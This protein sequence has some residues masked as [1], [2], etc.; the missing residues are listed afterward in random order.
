MLGLRIKGKR[1]FLRKSAL[2]GGSDTYI[3]IS[4]HCYIGARPTNELR[5]SISLRDAE[6][7]QEVL[8][9]E[10]CPKHNPNVF[11]NGPLFSGID[12]QLE[13]C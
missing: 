1:I 6:A 8:S 5:K 4:H 12:G 11:A 10:I 13:R 2:L 9:G 3:I 7:T